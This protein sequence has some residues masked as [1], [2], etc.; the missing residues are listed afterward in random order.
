MITTILGRSKTLTAAGHLTC[1][2]TLARGLDASQDVWYLGMDGY[3]EL[4][5]VTGTA[6]LG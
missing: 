2:W 1:T 6:V 4:D 3:S 5:G